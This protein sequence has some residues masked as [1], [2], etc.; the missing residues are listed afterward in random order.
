MAFEAV[1]R[2][3]P[4]AAFSVAALLVA[5]V[6]GQL[7]QALHFAQT[8]HERCAEHGELVHVEGQY[9]GGAERAAAS[10]ATLDGR[11]AAAAEH[12]HD[13]CS[14][15]TCDRQRAGVAPTGDLGIGA[16]AVAPSPS[17]MPGSLQPARVDLHLL[18]PKASPPA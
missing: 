8:R 2:R 5:V 4:A 11:P 3:A 15:A 18:A 17:A 6:V 12:G 10:R 13:H 1:R 7:G 14:L 16:M 9:A